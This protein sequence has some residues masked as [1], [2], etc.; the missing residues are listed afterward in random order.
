MDIRAGLIAELQEKGKKLIAKFEEE[1]K[2]I[3]QSS[4]DLEG[5]KNVDV[6]AYEGVFNKLYQIAT[7]TSLNALSIQVTPWDRNIL[8]KVEEAIK[9][10]Y[11]HTSLATKDNSVFVNFPPLTEENLQ[12]VVKELSK[13][14]EEFRQSL[15]RIR[16][17]VKSQLD[18]AKNANEI[19]DEQYRKILEDID[20]ETR[21]IREQIESL[22]DTKRK[23]ILGN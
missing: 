19:S 5:I 7:V 1:L 14:T 12:K 4:A 10:A 13:L 21:K 23:S 3:R 15:R 9:K 11:P 22:A 20:K 18:E 6:E 16:N 17:S 2:H 8:K